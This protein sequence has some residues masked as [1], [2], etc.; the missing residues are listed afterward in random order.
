MKTRIISAAVLVPIVVIGIVLGGVVWQVLAVIVGALAIF[1]MA[2]ALRNAEIKPM[3]I[4]DLLY[5]LASGACIWAGSMHLVFA[6]LLVFLMIAGTVSMLLPNKGIKDAIAT[7]FVMVYPT[8][9]VLVLALV[10]QFGWVYIVAGILASVVTDTAAYFIGKQFGKKKLCPNIS[11]N[12]TVIGALA[13]AFGCFVLLSVFGIL[14]EVFIHGSIGAVKTLG[15]LVLALLC[16]VFAQLGDLFASSIKRFCGVKDF[17]SLIP[18]HG[19]VVDRLDSVMFTC[20][21][22]YLFRLLGII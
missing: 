12:K 1:E 4:L 18:G 3:V 19:G 14:C 22:V 8:S 2:R 13:G 20:V 17:S 21:L 16:G 9:F 11:P 10:E 6:V 5:L 7:V 15:W